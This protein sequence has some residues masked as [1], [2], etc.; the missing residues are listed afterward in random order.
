MSTELLSRPSNAVSHG[1]IV[2]QMFDIPP[3]T[4]VEPERP[5]V[6]LFGARIDAL[7]MRQAVARLMNWIGERELA[8]RYVVTPNVDHCVLL[9]ESADLRAAYARASL[10]LADGM[11]VVWASRLLGKPLPERVTG[12]DLVPELFTAADPTRPLTAFLL[13]AAPG[14]AE[15]AATKIEARWPA[16]KVVGTYSPP[17][18]FEKDEAEC[19]A[20][21]ARVNAV[22]PDVLVLGFGAPKQEF[23]IH[24]HAPRLQAGVALCVGATI[25]FLAGEKSRAPRWLGRLGLEWAHRV[26]TEPRRLFARYWRDARMFPGLLWREWCDNPGR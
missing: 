8:C 11:P 10:V 23:W 21:H 20:I 12:A 17:L 14:V 25:D 19:Q 16:V 24:K 6:Q 9:S 18:G 5:P 7:T 26:A 4:R 1:E 2:S 13:G 3:E 22:R 15:R